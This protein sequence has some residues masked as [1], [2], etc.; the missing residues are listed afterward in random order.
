MT[1]VS[2]HR[3]GGLAPADDESMVVAD[4]GTYTVVRT[5]GGPRVG[6][7]AGRL[8]PGEL[9]ALSAAVGG[10]S[11]DVSTP[12]DLDGARE[13]IDVAG[14]IAQIGDHDRPEGAWGELVALVRPLL[15]R[16]STSGQTAGL[17]LKAN[18]TKVQVQSV[19]DEVFDIDTGSLGLTVVAARSD[20][21]TADRYDAPRGA[22]SF[23]TAGPGWH[24]VIDLPRRVD[25]PPG[26]YLR[27][28][29]AVP[30]RRAGRV[31]THRLFVAVP[32]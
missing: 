32:G 5:V 16:L 24:Y 22:S 10:V 9:E 6:H 13:R 25:P 28:T 15:D 21:G 12:G 29:V 2:Y 17:L 27:A 18:P 19:G 31:V 23:V 20:G 4:D 7:F 11:G 14:G 3:G 1:L 30:V 26:G 8:E